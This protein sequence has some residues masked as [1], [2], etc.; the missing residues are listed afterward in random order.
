MSVPPNGYDLF[1]YGCWP[2]VP[3]DT[4]VHPLYQQFLKRARELGYMTESGGFQDY[5][6]AYFQFFLAGA[7]VLEAEVERLQAEIQKLTWCGC[8]EKLS[9]PQCHVCDND[10]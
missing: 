7:G 4:K 6:D 1:R 8:G 9:S 5:E 3:V 2:L 10:E